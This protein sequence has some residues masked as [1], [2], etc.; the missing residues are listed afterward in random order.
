MRVGAAILTISGS[1]TDKI[2]GCPL[3]SNTGVPIGAF[4]LTD[5]SLED[6][7]STG[8]LLSTG[9]TVIVNLAVANLFNSELSSA[10]KTKIVT[11]LFIC[12]I[13]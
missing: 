5:P 10:C 11:L 9:R 6:T 12:H 7:V 13:T 4:S 1:V 8:G 2:M 3:L